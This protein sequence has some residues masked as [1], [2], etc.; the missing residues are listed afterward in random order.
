MNTHQK[1]LSSEIT[2]LL[3]SW[4]LDLH[5][6]RSVYAHIFRVDNWDGASAIRGTNSDDVFRLPAFFLGTLRDD[7]AVA[8]FLQ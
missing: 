6:G 7:V 5:Y 1:K 8:M 3:C 4:R 2:F